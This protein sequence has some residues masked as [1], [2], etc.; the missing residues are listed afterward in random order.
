MSDRIIVSRHPAAVEFIRSRMQEFASAPV[1]EVASP[2]VVRGKVVAGNLPLHLACLAS[3]VI[4]VEFDGAP[5]RG[6]EY[7]VA[8][9][10]A[11]GARLAR[12]TVQAVPEP[13]KEIK[14]NDG[15]G[16]RG[17][18]S[19]LLIGKGDQVVEF[20]GQ[21]VPGL[22]AVRSSKYEKNGKW[23]NTDYILVLSPG[24]WHHIESQ[25]WEEGEFFHGCASPSDAVTRLRKSG[26]VGADDT[27]LAFLGEKFP[28]T[29]ERLRETAASLKSV[30]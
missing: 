14:W 10:E 20:V 22:V 3:Q 1:L 15:I 21:S 24:A 16:N 25:S 9:M 2:E 6:Q 17:R 28:K 12:Y 30:E 18:R 5:P 23:S 29:M 7:G 8:E 27:M 19:K 13:Q 26:Y 4:A 11:A